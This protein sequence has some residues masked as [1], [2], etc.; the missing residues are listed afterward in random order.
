MKTCFSKAIA[1]HHLTRRQETPSP[2]LAAQDL[3]E[4]AAFRALELSG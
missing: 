4:C 2:E 1:T 3:G